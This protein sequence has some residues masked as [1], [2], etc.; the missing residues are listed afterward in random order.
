M[1]KLVLALVLAA[2]ASAP[3]LADKKKM[4]NAEQDAASMK[5]AEVGRGGLKE[6]PVSKEEADWSSAAASS[7]STGA[8]S[9][10]SGAGESGSNESGAN[11]AR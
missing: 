7:S 6:W 5:S 3:A 8:S 11:N 10:D 9:G 2:F 4:K 1:K